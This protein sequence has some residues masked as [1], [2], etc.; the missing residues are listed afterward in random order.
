MVSGRLL[1]LVSP[2]H[3]SVKEAP[4]D[5][6]YFDSMLTILDR[7]IINDRPWLTGVIDQPY[8]R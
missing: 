5:G 2:S 6:S 4:N 1:P 7:E 3:A 8:P